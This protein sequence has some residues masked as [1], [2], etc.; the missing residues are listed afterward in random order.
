MT[1]H[2]EIKSIEYKGIKVLLK[3][4]Y[5][6]GTV[7]MV[8]IMHANGDTQSVA[9]KWIF[10]GRGLEYMNGWLDILM[11]MRNA[12]L[13]AK[14]DLEQDLA[15]KSAFKKKNEI[16]VDITAKIGGKRI[17]KSRNTPIV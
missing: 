3:I 15:E 5:E 1:K 2:L 6:L 13:E 9:K 10:A 16:S 11:A 14:K 17:H 4:D 8:E 12:V 7:S